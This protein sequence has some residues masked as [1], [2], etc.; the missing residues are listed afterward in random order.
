[1]SHK[2]ALRASDADREKTG[3]EVDL[4]GFAFGGHR[5]P[6]GNQHPLQPGAPIV[7]VLALSVFAGIDVRRVP[8]AWTQKNWTDVI[9]GIR[10]GAHE[11]LA[12]R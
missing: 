2:P 4:H 11:E 5:R 7:R 1:V 10:A 12:A 9:R 6:R 8:D 3:V